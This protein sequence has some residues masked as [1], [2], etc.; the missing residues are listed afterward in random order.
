MLEYRAE[1]DA[2]IAELEQDKAIS[3]E[4]RRRAE[5]ANIAKSRFLA[6]ISHELRTPL[7]AILGFSEVMKSEI[8][9][10]H[11]KPDLQGIRQRHPSRAAST[12][13]ISSTRYSTSAR[14]EAGRYECMKGRSGSPKW[15]GCCCGPSISNRMISEKPRMA[16]SG[17]R[18]S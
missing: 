16:L 4:A 17:V 5:E 18:S 10:P 1:K 8:L 3:D 15:S 9:G 2:L 7:N 13:C 14:I 6:T 12:C 11:A